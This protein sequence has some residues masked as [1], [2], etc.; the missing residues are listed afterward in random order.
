LKA[1][2]ETGSTEMLAPGT[3]ENLQK[4]DSLDKFVNVNISELLATV[5]AYHVIQ[6]GPKGLNNDQVLSDLDLFVAMNSNDSSNASLAI[7]NL[8]I[9]LRRALVKIRAI[10]NA[11]S[12]DLIAI[13][14]LPPILPIVR[15]LQALLPSVVATLANK[16]KLLPLADDLFQEMVVKPTPANSAAIMK[17]YGPLLME[18]LGR[19]RPLYEA[20][21]DITFAACVSVLSPLSG[22]WLFLGCMCLLCTTFLTFLLSLLSKRS[23]ASSASE[24]LHSTR[25]ITTT[26]NNNASSEHDVVAFLPHKEHFDMQGLRDDCSDVSGKHEQQHLS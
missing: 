25:N 14:D 17:K 16:T 2:N 18:K 22:Q 12:Q 8:T 9:N 5:E 7:H 13:R 3:L 11:A 6:E 1:M 15:E 26:N 20:Y 21:R 4:A 23:S 24:P 10:Q 19:C